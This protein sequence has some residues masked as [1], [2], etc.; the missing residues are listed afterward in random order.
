VDVVQLPDLYPWLKIVHILLAVVAVGFNLSYGVLISRAVREPDHLRHV[1]QTVKVLD[2][3]FANPAYALLLVFGLLLV[4][5]GPWEFTD[6]WILVSLGLYALAVGVGAAFYSP[7]LR[8][9]IAA[10]DEHGPASPEYKV[11]AIRGRNLGMFLGAV[12]AVIIALM[13]LKPTL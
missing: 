11:L 8:R 2:D 5:I 12:V 7:T 10:V 1:L 13:V 9:Q 6:L 3:R 4:L